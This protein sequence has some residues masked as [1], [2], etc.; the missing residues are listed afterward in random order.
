LWLQI[1]QR[2]LRRKKNY[3]ELA[4][5][6]AYKT[7]TSFFYMHSIKSVGNRNFKLGIS[8]ISPEK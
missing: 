6:A 3:D 4:V 2:S 8:T 1:S 7:V 5:H